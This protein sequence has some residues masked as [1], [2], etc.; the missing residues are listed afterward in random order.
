VS[1][2]ATSLLMGLHSN[3]PP[4]NRSHILLVS[5]MLVPGCAQ[6]GMASVRRENVGRYPG[7]VQ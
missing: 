2:K 3:E 5:C 4:A 6:C 1:D 7:N